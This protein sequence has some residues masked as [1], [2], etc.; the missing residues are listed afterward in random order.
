PPM[1]PLAPC[2]TV[3]VCPASVR[4]P[5]RAPPVFSALSLHDALPIFPL[6]PLVTVIHAAVLTAVHAH[7]APAVTLTLAAPPAA[8]GLAE[9]G[10]DRK[11]TRLTSSHVE[12]SP[13]A[14]CLQKRALP[15]F[16]ATV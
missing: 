6:A 14:F 4:L 1:L 10:E 13:A 12:I 8:V 2:F 9:V 7:P 3:T 5:E 11:S 16:A 15:V